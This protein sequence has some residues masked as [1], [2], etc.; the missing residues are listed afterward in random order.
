VRNRLPDGWG[1]E[2]DD[3]FT[4]TS[5]AQGIMFNQVVVAIGVNE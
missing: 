3:Y 5:F 4:R 2:R 1:W